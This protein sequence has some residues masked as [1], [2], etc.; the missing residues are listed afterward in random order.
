MNG[1]AC[2]GASPCTGMSRQAG[3]DI[4]RQL[5]RAGADSRGL[6]SIGGLSAQYLNEL[7]PRWNH[8]SP[9]KIDQADEM[10][11]DEVGSNVQRPSARLHMQLD[12]FARTCRMP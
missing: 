11:H 3:L 4:K 7:L 5:E 9:G 10:L 8:Y 6:V 12:G 2:R 1:A